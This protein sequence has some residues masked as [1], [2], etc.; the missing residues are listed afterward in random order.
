MILPKDEESKASESI[1]IQAVSNFC[2]NLLAGDCRDRRIDLLAMAEYIYFYYEYHY[3][4]HPALRLGPDTGGLADT[5]FCCG[6]SI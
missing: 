5:D 3:R 2:R 6:N 1:W 4:H